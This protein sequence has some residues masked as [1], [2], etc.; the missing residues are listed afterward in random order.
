MEKLE[1]LKKYFGY[2]SFRSGQ[3][4]IIDSI[5]NKKETL[6]IMPTGG[7]KSICYQVP[8]MIFD[9]VTIVISPLISL[10]KDQVNALSANGI[11]AVCINSLSTINEQSQI[12]NFVLS[13]SVKLVYVAPERL[14]SD[15]FLDV[16]SRINISMVAVD[17]AHCISQWG[18][19]FRTS[20]TEIASFVKKLPSNPLIC[21]FTATATPQVREDIIQRLELKNPNTFITGFDRKNLKFSVITGQNS[22]DFIDDYLEN[23]KQESGIIYASTRKEVDSIYDDLKA[24][25]YRVGKYH[26]GLKPE[27]R[28]YF[29]DEFI[30]DNLNIMVATNAFGMGID[31]S[32]VRF[33]IHNNLTKDIES[34]Y[35]EAGRAGR[36]GLESECILVFNPK[37][38]F[39]QNFFINNAIENT[40]PE[41]TEIKKQKLNDIINYCNTQKCLREYILKYFG[42]QNTTSNCGNCSNCLEESN[43]VDIT[44]E[45][46]KIISCIFKLPYPFGST[47]I[48]NILKGS[49]DKKIL[50]NSFDKLSTYGIMSNLSAKEIRGIINSLVADDYLSINSEY[51]TLSISQKGVGVIKNA[52]KVYRKMVKM[53]KKETSFDN[54]IILKL[55]DFRKKLAE[56]EKV[57]PYIIFSDKSLQDIANYAPQTKED[58]LKLKGFGE[59]KVEKYGQQIIDVVKELEIT[60]IKE[61]K[62]KKEKKQ[63]NKSV[64]SSAIESLRMYKSGM[65]IEEIAKERGFV[66]ATIEGHIFSTIT[67]INEIDFTKIINAD[68]EQKIRE[69]IAKLGSEALSPIKQALG[70]DISYTQIKA[71]FCKMRLNP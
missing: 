1:I 34:Y 15:S 10:M 6:A 58:L 8:A 32:N 26:A 51:S 40:T 13:G 53:S 22:R 70:D 43:L 30:Y 14:F 28:Q 42:E 18:H 12:L 4:K 11:T 21:A 17:E 67:D 29:Q 64:G 16:M 59:Y 48:A 55:K 31:K 62:A 2:S 24:N 33:V 45:A 41:I 68:E 23:H 60:A 27:E 44:I 47:M 65:T 25:G 66:K 49:K 35:Q 57:P 5:L 36:D 7:G 61:I 9:G 37:D 19:D 63:R 56:I 54:E 69:A 50:E 71:V 46:Q 39:T 3:D 38:I 20:Y 52:E